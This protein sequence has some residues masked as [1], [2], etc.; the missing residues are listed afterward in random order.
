MELSLTSQILL[1][2]IA[3]IFFTIDGLA[4]YRSAAEEKKSWFSAI[5][6]AHIIL[7]PLGPIV[8][9]IL[10]ILYLFVFAKHKLTK[11]EIF[12]WFKSE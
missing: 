1:I 12:S 10:S 9:I 6:V 11:K 4:L 3:I 7:I 8:S 2:I 5:F